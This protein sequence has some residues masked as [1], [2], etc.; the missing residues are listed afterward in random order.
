MEFKVVSLGDKL[1]W[2]GPS[3]RKGLETATSLNIS[4]IIDFE[5]D[6]GSIPNPEST[7]AEMAREKLG[8]E[9]LET[10]EDPPY[11]P[12]TIY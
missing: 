7:M 2:S 3:T 4:A 6:S 12:G 5:P 1:R 11:T 8:A 10:A 9:V